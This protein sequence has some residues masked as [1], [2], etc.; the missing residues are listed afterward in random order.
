MMRYNRLRRCP[1]S[2][3]YWGGGVLVLYSWFSLFSENS[4]RIIRYWPL[5]GTVI[6]D[7][8]QVA[9]RFYAAW[10][11]YFNYYF[12]MNQSFYNRFCLFIF[13]VKYGRAHLRE[14]AIH[15]VPF[16]HYYSERRWSLEDGTNQI[17]KDGKDKVSVGADAGTDELCR[18][19]TLC[20]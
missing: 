14:R 4:F 11:K 16:G 15:H 1:G 6:S 5:S 17:K 20:G 19:D 2:F 3:S 13:I 10:S 12:H 9:H 7:V 8:L 18:C